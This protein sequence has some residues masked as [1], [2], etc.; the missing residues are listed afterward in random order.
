M[1]AQLPYLRNINAPDACVT[2]DCWNRRR[3]HVLVAL[4]ETAMMC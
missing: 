4:R 2:D 3:M 1:T